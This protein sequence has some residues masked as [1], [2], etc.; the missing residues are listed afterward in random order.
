[1]NL[2]HA[3]D[4]SEC[5]ATAGRLLATLPLPADTRVTVLSAVPHS[6]W[7]ATPRYGIEAQAYATLADRPRCCARVRSPRFS[8]RR[9]ETGVT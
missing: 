4:G 2:L 3:T 7:L 8:T 6:A 9:G 5:A 1:M